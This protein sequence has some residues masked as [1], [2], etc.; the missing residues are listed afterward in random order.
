MRRQP[1]KEQPKQ[2]T[3]RKAPVAPAAPKAPEAPKKAA[4]GGSVKAL[5]D[6]GWKLTDKGDNDGA[7]DLFLKAIELDPAN[8][9]AYY[10][11]GYAY[12]AKG[13]KAKAR[14]YYQKALNARISA[15]DRA[16]IEN[17]LNNL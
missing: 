13:Q 10:G 16:D 15:A 3:A 2:E 17:I 8:G 14:E 6:R 7:I 4:G 11:L 5:V 9:Q 1:P 12:Q